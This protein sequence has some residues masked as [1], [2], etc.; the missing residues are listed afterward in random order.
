MTTEE[1]P[2]RTYPSED[3]LRAEAVR[4]AR[5]AC[6]G[7][8]GRVLGD[9]VFEQVTEGRNRWKGYSSC[10]DLPHFV[11]K[12][13][14][15][16]DEHILNRNDDDGVVP[17][18]MG[19]N[20]ARLVFSSGQAFRWARGSDRPR[21]G[22]ILYMS[23]PEHVCVLESLDEQAGRITTFDYGQWDK[24]RGKPAGKRVSRRFGV[25][26]RVLKVGRRTLHG[27]LDISRLPGLIAA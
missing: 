25:A 23:A 21:P 24:K 1:R 14:G 20:L 15:L 6:N 8:E 5:Y 27:W 4:I 26:G 9:P 7:D 11:L 3:A 19:V 2:A 22:D 18:K 16:R 12:E 10:G 13:L 17:W